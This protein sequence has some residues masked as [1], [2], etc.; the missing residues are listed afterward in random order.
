M[1]RNSNNRRAFS[2]VELVVVVLIMG[3]LAAVAAPKMF[4]TSTS[5]KQNS[6]RQSLATLRDAIELYKAQNGSYP[7]A[8][9][10]STGLASYLK[11]P[12]PQVQYG[13]HSGTSTVA[14]STDNPITS[15]SGS[16]AWIYNESTGEI[17]VN[18]N[19]GFSW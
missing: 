18:D 1:L 19:T 9:T 10:L 6:T 4:D 7:A 11:G 17:H 5:A 8:A 13:S 12:F 2:L 15:A 14:A 16:E 3:I